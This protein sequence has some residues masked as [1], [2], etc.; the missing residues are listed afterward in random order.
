MDPG[1]IAGLIVGW[2]GRKLIKSSEEYNRLEE[3]AKLLDDII[4]YDYGQ[5]RAVKMTFREKGEFIKKY[6]PLSATDCWFNEL[7]KDFMLDK[8]PYPPHTFSYF[9]NEYKQKKLL[10]A[11]RAKILDDIIVKE[12]GAKAGTMT[13]TEKSEFVMKYCCEGYMLRGTPADITEFFLGV[14]PRNNS[15]G[16]FNFNSVPYNCFISKYK[17]ISGE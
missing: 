15:Y 10:A 2:V 14:N 8:Y 13:M 4:S 16:Q 5:E 11:Q 6:S 17:K 7:R 12:F 9:I 3:R 1:T